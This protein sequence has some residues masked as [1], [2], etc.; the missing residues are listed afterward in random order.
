MKKTHFI[1]AGVVG[2]LIIAVAMY[3]GS[4]PATHVGSARGV[5]AQE[6]ARIQKHESANTHRAL[7][8][9][10]LQWVCKIYK[11]KIGA[12]EGDTIHCDKAGSRE[13]EKTIKDAYSWD[14]F[15][16]MRDLPEAP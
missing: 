16:D 11:Q 4:P 8:Y 9:R 2:C 5:S 15:G 7:A 14:H 12:S 13:F 3:L 6:M 1:L 10:Q